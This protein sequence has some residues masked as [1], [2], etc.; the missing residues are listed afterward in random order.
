MSDLLL[1]HNKFKTRINLHQLNINIMYGE[2]SVSDVKHSF[3]FVSGGRYKL[4]NSCTRETLETR[5]RDVFVV[6]VQLFNRNC[7]VPSSLEWALRDNTNTVTR[8]V[9]DSYFL[10]FWVEE[11]CRACG[12]KNN[13]SM[14]ILGTGK[15]CYVFNA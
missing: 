3:I 6:V 8:C 1:I 4:T 5:R 10:T 12:K 13:R 14:N 2:V 15:S 9:T 7:S 11:H